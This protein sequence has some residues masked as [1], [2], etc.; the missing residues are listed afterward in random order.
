MRAIHARVQ[1]VVQGVGFRYYTARV[2]MALELTGW[3]RNLDDGSVEVSAQGPGDAV[4]EFVAFLEVGPAGA[5][6]TGCLVE[7]VAT[8]PNYQNF[9]VRF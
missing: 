9:E 2:A 3:V 7:D 8:D 5:S 6:V 1:G 4:A